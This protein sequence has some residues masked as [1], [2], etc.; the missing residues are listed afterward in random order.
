MLITKIDR[1]KGG[2]L[3]IMCGDE[4]VALL[5]RKT[6][7]EHDIGVGVSVPESVLA[8]LQFESDCRRALTAGLYL[9][10]RKEV[11]RSQVINKLAP[12]YGHEAAEAAADELEK[13]GFVNDRRYAEMLAAIYFE[14]R[15][16][17][18]RRVMLE[19]TRKGVSR[20][21]AHEVCEEL[22]PDEEQAIKEL[23]SG[24]LGRDLSSDTGKRRVYS[25]LERYGYSSYTI[26]SVMRQYLDNGDDDY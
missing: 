20:E 15:H 21:I 2:L 12:N 24:R 14:D 26:R 5:D 25:A 19:L 3:A 1:V 9:V 22:A 18:T 10:A 11:C 7:E 16:F 6:V 13:L 8:E 23:L 17:Y 4:Q